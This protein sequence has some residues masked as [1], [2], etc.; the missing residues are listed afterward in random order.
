MYQY[1]FLILIYYLN[2]ARGLWLAYPLR[3]CRDYWIKY[4]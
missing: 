1:H 3:T 2:F 4:Q